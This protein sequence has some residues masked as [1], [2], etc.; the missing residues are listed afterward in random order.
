MLT[1][2]WHIGPAFVLPL[3]LI[4]WLKVV[5]ERLV[6]LFALLKSAP[7]VW[8]VHASTA[9]SPLPTLGLGIR[10]LG[11]DIGSELVD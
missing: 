3:A 1:P 8:G 9:A 5:A 6:A 10:H 7:P 4:A 2:Q 11:E